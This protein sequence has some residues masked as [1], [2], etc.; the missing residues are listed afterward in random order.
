MYLTASNLCGLRRSRIDHRF[1][2][3]LL[4]KAPLIGTTPFPM[5]LFLPIS[6]WIVKQ[7]LPGGQTVSFKASSTSVF[8]AS[9]TGLDSN[10]P[11]LMRYVKWINRMMLSLP[12]KQTAGQGGN[13]FLN[14]YYVLFRVDLN[15]GQRIRYWLNMFYE[16]RLGGKVA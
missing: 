14:I 7:S 10:P 8:A 2:S 12:T 9:Q 5:P 4:R 11:A 6:G 15:D 16:I 13:I 3:R 1:L